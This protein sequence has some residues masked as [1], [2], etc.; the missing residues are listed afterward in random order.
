MRVPT[1]R[2][3]GADIW[4]LGT[5]L[6]VE[7]GASDHVFGHD[8]EN[9]PAISHTVRI[10]PMTRRVSSFYQAA[11]RDSRHGSVPTGHIG[12]QVMVTTASIGNRLLRPSLSALV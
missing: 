11:R 12:K 5:I 7:N 4:G 2:M 1:A 3:V 9:Y 10:D 6:Y 8:G